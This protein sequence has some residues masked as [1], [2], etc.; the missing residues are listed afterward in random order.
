MAIGAESVSRRDDVF[1]APPF[2]LLSRGMKDSLT[3]WD[4]LEMFATRKHTYALTPQRS[5]LRRLLWRSSVTSRSESSESS[6]EE[7]PLAQLR[8]PRSGP[9]CGFAIASAL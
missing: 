4:V 8:H 7:T 9:R 6:D 1:K 2:S 5:K 3:N